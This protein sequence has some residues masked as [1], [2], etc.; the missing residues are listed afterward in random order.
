ML[1]LF[2]GVC[3]EYGCVWVT[4]THLGL[5]ALQ[6]WEEGGV[7]EGRLGVTEAWGHIPGHTEVRI[8]DG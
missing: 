3:E 7:Q 6:C 4:S 2:H 8:L 5:R 1:D